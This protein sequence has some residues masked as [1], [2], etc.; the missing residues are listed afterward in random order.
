MKK[1]KKDIEEKEKIFIG[2]RWVE[3]TQHTPKPTNKIILGLE[4]ALIKTLQKLFEV[5]SR[6]CFFLGFLIPLGVI[7]FI[8]KLVEG[9]AFTFQV[10][11]TFLTPLAIY[12]L[13]YIT[14]FIADWFEERY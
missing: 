14:G 1:F 2:G 9:E 5:L 3:V 6:L 4:I 13:G 8:W 7:Y 11:S 10:I 12:F